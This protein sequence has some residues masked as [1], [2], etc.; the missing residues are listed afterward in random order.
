MRPSLDLSKVTRLKDVEFQPRGQNVKWISAALRTIRSENLQQITIR[1][2]TLL[3]SN[4]LRESASESTRLEW[5]D[6][7]HLLVELWITRSIRPVFTYERMGAV[8]SPDVLVPKLLPELVNS[9]VI[10][11]V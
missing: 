5:K 1:F 7:D 4:V 6:L 11:F 9:G 10:N 8:A 3:M 2:Y